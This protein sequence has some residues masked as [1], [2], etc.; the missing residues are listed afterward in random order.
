MLEMFLPISFLC[1]ISHLSACPGAHRPRCC[2]TLLLKEVY[3]LLLLPPMQE[4]LPPGGRDERIVSWPHS[5]GGQVPPVR[6]GGAGRSRP[7][8]WSR[9]CGR[10]GRKAPA[11][12][13]PELSPAPAPASP[14]LSA[15]QGGEVGNVQV[16]GR[17]GTPRKA[18]GGRRTDRQGAAG[19]TGAEL[20][21]KL[22]RTKP[23]KFWVFFLRKKKLHF[24][25]RN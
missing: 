25:R 15:G 9:G 11:P 12:C 19:E 4:N 2:S 24:F 21:V 7:C 6:L 1:S 5:P 18:G 14:P 16:V 17:S 23:P 22:R 3:A 20:L 13:P 10:R 8:P